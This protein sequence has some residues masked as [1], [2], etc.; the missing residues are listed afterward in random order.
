MESYRHRAGTLWN[1]LWEDM[2]V[3][4]ALK[5]SGQVIRPIT[6]RPLIVQWNRPAID[7]KLWRPDDIHREDI[8]G[9]RTGE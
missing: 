5:R 8:V 3:G 9:A 1:A 6:G 2:H 4:T 7:P